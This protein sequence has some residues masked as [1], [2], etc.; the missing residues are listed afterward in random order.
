MYRWWNPFHIVASHSSGPRAS[1]QNVN[2]GN[3]HCQ[4]PGIQDDTNSEEQKVYIRLKNLSEVHSNN[5]EVGW[6]YLNTVNTQYTHS[7][8]YRGFKRL[9][10]VQ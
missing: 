9:N 5:F 7:T 2:K 3:Y 8:V 1:S 6:M 4:S 10:T